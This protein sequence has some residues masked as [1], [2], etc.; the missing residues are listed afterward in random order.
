MSICI[1]CG[2]PCASSHGC[3]L[4]S[5]PDIALLPNALDSVCN[6]QIMHVA[7]QLFAAELYRISM[8]TALRKSVAQT[9]GSRARNLGTI[10][11]ATLLCHTLPPTAARPA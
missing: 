3:S 2:L 8:H 5:H 10:A 6:I 4:A 7:E 1:A 9:K 11:H